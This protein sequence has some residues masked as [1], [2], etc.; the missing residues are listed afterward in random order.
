MNELASA[1]PAFLGGIVIGAIFF[2]GLW[3]TVRTGLTARHPAWWFLGSFA[4]RMS[5]AVGGFFLVA[6]GDLARLAA[7]LLGF[8]VARFAVTRLTRTSG[9]KNAKSLKETSHAP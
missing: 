8:L 9:L 1:T 3:W 7:G 4:V 2:G 5:V 6:R